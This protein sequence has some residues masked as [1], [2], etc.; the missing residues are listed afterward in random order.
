MLLV[1][2]TVLF[3][4][5]IFHMFTHQSKKLSMDRICPECGDA[6]LGRADKKFCSDQCRN[7]FNN[8]QKRDSTNYMRNV[9]NIL[10]KNR[11]ILMALNPN[12]K[13][14]LHRDKLQARGFN[15]NYFT[16][17]Y[18]T[19]IGTVYYFCYEYGYL[20][21]EGDFLALVRRDEFATI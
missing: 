12:G 2:G 17:T 19:K 3:H 20:S 10:K 16:N 7:T 15:F 8:S 4:N 14:K 6:I 18:T 11:L 5:A 1:A 21:L 13:T 9:N